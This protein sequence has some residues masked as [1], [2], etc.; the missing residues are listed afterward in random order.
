MTESVNGK[1]G[2]D[3]VRSIG[4]SEKTVAMKRKRG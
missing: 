2:E 3:V 1:G 4:Q